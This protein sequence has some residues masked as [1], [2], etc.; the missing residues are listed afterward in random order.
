MDDWA[1]KQTTSLLNLSVIVVA[2]QGEV[3]AS[4]ASKRSE[5]KQRGRQ[6]LY[7]QQ[8]RRRETLL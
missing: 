3:E 7:E 6:A 2:E 1:Q 4:A 5:A 8:R